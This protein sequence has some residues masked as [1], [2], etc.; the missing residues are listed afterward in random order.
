MRI[1]GWREEDTAA[2]NCAEADTNVQAAQGMQV[3][4]GQLTEEA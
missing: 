4:R 2:M 3:N 1:E